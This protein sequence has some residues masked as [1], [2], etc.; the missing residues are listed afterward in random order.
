MDVNTATLA[1]LSTLPYDADPRL[2]DSLL[3]FDSL[4]FVTEGVKIYHIEP[5]EDLQKF[6]RRLVGGN[7]QSYSESQTKTPQRMATEDVVTSLISRIIIKRVF[8]VEM[9]QQSR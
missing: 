9:S 8:T 4:E 7:H 5:D 2:I 3:S 6:L 1:M